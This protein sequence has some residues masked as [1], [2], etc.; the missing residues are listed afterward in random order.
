[1][2]TIIAYA[3]LVSLAYLFGSIPFGIVLGPLFR[4]G[5][6]R[7]IGSGNIGA[8]NALRTGNK[9]FALCVLIADGAK[10]AVAIFVTRTLDIADTL[11]HAALVAGLVAII[12]HLFPVWLKFKGGK[13]VA[14]ALGVLLA[15]HW[16]TGVA[17]AIMWL[18]TARL[19]RYSSLSAI[20]AFL[21]APLYAMAFGGREYAIPFAI[22]AVLI[23]ITHRENIKRL[24]AG[25]ES[26]IK[27]K[28]ST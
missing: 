13:G 19:G 5:D 28:K 23:C 20:L 21:N 25:T 18:V 17:A 3:A 26:T 9:V 11:P 4:V 27:L 15:L 24:I 10:G 6:I 8:T 7:T 14:T 2:D 12:G 16:P 1:M 22:L